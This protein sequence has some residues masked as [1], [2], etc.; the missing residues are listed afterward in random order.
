[1]RKNRSNRGLTL[2]ELMITLAVI[3]IVGLIAVPG[4]FKTI[5]KYRADRAAKILATEMNLARMRAIAKNRTHQVDFDTTNQDI[6]VKE[7]DPSVASPTFNLVKNIAF[8]DEFPNVMLGYNNV[9][10]VDGGS[11]PKPA[12]FGQ[13]ATTV[14]MFLPN[15]MLQES[16]VFYLIPTAD[17]AA[18]RNDRM[19]AIEVGRAGQITLWRYDDSQTPPWRAF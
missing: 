1:M 18:G 6:D 3:G 2:V 12:A 17:K 8:A 5:P 14:A 19:R 10:G 4:I 7:Q 11:I 16:G 15:G 9:T 13:A